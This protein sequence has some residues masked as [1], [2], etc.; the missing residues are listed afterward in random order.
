[1]RNNLDKRQSIAEPMERDASR[2]QKHTEDGPG[3]E[4]KSGWKSVI[5]GEKKWNIAMVLLGLL[6][7][8]IVLLA[9][10]YMPNIVPAHYNA[11]GE[12][13]RWGSKYEDLILPL[14][15]L[16]ICA[17]WLVGEIPLERGVHKDSNSEMGPKTTVRMWAIGG[18]CM[19]A[20]F[21]AMTVWIVADAFSKGHTGSKIPLEA[22]INVVTGLVFIVIGNVMPNAKMNRWSGIRVPG[23]FKSRESWRRCQRFGGFVFI[24]GGVVLVVFGL[25]MHTQDR[26]NLYAILA[27]TLII[28][29]ACYVY[30]IYAGKKYGN[31]GGPIKGQ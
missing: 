20:V 10:P 6:P 25:A 5:A 23:A 1:M 31:V 24:L 2:V 27:V 9:L 29:L 7:L 21:S 16:L 22:V 4:R 15:T 8:I 30:G 26:M 17:G 13:D 3:K 18:C 14:L 11:S 19:F 12:L 28:V